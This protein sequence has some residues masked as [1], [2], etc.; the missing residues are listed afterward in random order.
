MGLISSL[1]DKLIIIVLRPNWIVNSH[2]FLASDCSSSFHAFAGQLLIRLSSNLVEEIITGL[3][4]P[5]WLLV[6]PFLP[7]P[8]L[9]WLSSFC[10]FAVKTL[11][12]LGS[13]LVAQIIMYLSQPDE[14][15]VM[16]SLIPTVP[17]PRICWA[18]SML[19]RQTTEE[20]ELKFG[21]PTHYGTH[22][23]WLTFG[24]AQLIT[25]FSGLFFFFFSS[26]CAFADWSDWAQ[27][28]W[29]N[30]FHA[31]PKPDQLLAMLCW[32]L[33]LIVGHAS[34]DAVYIYLKFHLF[35]HHL[36]IHLFIV[37]IYIFVFRVLTITFIRCFIYSAFIHSF[38]HSISFYLFIYLE[39]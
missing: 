38:I 4:W 12:G 13:N 32:I 1:V 27:I 37:Y 19:C 6:M 10:A 18:V 11:V 30:S 22:P 23:V 16:L 5:N 9:W 14:L 36:S 20:I 29:V 15:L 8:D 17:C 26:F 35:I 7:F 31:S 2:H 28:W 25:L 33:A 34:T 21:G 39:C 24:C 3:L